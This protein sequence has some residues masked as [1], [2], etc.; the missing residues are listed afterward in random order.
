[1]V[2]RRCGITHVGF[3]CHSGR[4]ARTAQSKGLMAEN[5]PKQKTPNY[6]FRE[7]IQTGFRG[8]QR[9]ASYPDWGVKRMTKRQ[10]QKHRQKAGIGGLGSQVEKPQYPKSSACFLY[11][12]EQSQGC[13]QPNREAGL[14][15][16]GR[17]SPWR[18]AGFGC[19]HPERLALWRAC[20]TH[21]GTWTRKNGFAISL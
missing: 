7:E 14:A 15:N 16:L 1:M 8:A 4:E 10:R 9:G 17:C 2:P 3:M 19:A 12:V 18:G 6:K 11:S 13:V 21:I 5:S 20:T